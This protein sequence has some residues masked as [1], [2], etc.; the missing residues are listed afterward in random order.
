MLSAIEI[1]DKA[2]FMAKKIIKKNDYTK[3]M[4]LEEFKKIV[5]DNS[6][7]LTRK[8]IEEYAKN[9]LRGYQDGIEDAK[10]SYINEHAETSI[11]YKQELEKLEI[12]MIDIIS[13]V[14]EKVAYSLKSSEY[15]Q[16]ALLDALATYRDDLIVSYVSPAHREAVEELEE[17]I[18]SKYDSETLKVRFDENL[19]DSSCIIE[20][21]FG[22]VDLS[23]DTK[24]KN[25]KRA[26]EKALSESH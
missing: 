19:S 24:I 11:K 22:Q 18:K 12:K 21:K 5:H 14:T 17:Q 13:E 25:Y 4:S 20:T 15:I 26:L 16:G 23:R 8:T 10:N 6:K 1:D 7:T 2:I 3:L 9:K